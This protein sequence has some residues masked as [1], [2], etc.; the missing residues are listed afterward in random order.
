VKVYVPATMHGGAGGGGCIG[1]ARRWKH[2][3]V[4][5]TEPVGGGTKQQFLARHV[6]SICP[7]FGSGWQSKR[8]C[9]SS[10]PIKA[11][12][13]D[14]SISLWSCEEA[15]GSQRPQRSR[16]RCRRA[17]R[18]LLELRVRRGA[19]RNASTLIGCLPQ[20]VTAPRRISGHSNRWSLAAMRSTDPVLLS[21]QV[22]TAE[23][24]G[25]ACCAVHASALLLG[26]GGTGGVEGGGDVLLVGRPEMPQTRPPAS[27]FHPSF[28]EVLLERA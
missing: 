28:H 2:H 3:G 10:H 16:R 1:G 27:S 14:T 13:G 22:H 24:P 25:H 8:T 6:A 18:N 7:V 17:V 11:S 21:E 5:G 12:G 9:P 26:V 20:L 15:S 4:P 19:T 23:S